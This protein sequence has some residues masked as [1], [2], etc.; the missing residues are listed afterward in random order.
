MATSVVS[1]SQAASTNLTDA[2]GVTINAP[3]SIASGDFLVAVLSG[4]YTGSVVWSA[5]PGWTLAASDHAASVSLE[6]RI[7]TKTVTGS[8]PSSYGWT[9]TGGAGSYA[10]VITAYRGTI[11][12]GTV[13]SGSNPNSHVNTTSQTPSEPLVTSPTWPGLGTYA[14]S[15]HATGSTGMSCTGNI[16]T[17]RGDISTTDG[18]PS[19]HERG[20]AVYTHGTNHA[21]GSYTGTGTMT[22]SAAPTASVVWTIDLMDAPAAAWSSTAPAATSSWT[23][24]RTNRLTWAS[25][26]AAATGAFVAGRAGPLVELKINGTWTDVTDFVRYEEGITVT[27]GRSAE[28]TTMSTSTCTF[29]LDNRTDTAQNRWSLH[30]VNGIYYGL[31][32]RN[33]EIRVSKL[34]GSYRFWGEISSWTPGAD[35][36]NND[37]WVEIEAAGLSRRLEANAARVLPAIQREILAASPQPL[38]YWPMTEGQGSTQFASA[39][40]GGAPMSYKGGLPD[41]GN[42]TN[43]AAG[44]AIPQINTASIALPYVPGSDMTTGYTF[45]F[46]LASPGGITAQTTLLTINPIDGFEYNGYTYRPYWGVGY[47]TTNTLAMDIFPGSDSGGEISGTVP[48]VGTNGVMVYASVDVDASA[49]PAAGRMH[50]Y[51]QGEGDASPVLVGSSTWGLQVGDN[52]PTKVAARINPN[53]AA[54]SDNSAAYI[55]HVSQWAGYAI[56]YSFESI[57]AYSGEAAGDRFLRL[58]SEKGIPAVCDNSS[59]ST[60][61]GP[62]RPKTFME[63]VRECE[64][65]DL[66]IL[67]ETRDQLGFRYIVRSDLYNKAA[68][69]VLD[70]SN[71]ELS[72]QLQPV[73]DDKGVQN[74]VT[75]QRDGGSSAEYVVESGPLSVNDPPNGVGRYTSSETVSLADDFDCYAQAGWRAH[76]GTV[77]EERIA[78]VGVALENP[79]VDSNHNLKLNILDADS[80]SRL[81]ILNTPDWIQ[82]VDQIVQGLSERFDNF[83][84]QITYNT[85]SAAPYTIAVAPTTTTSTTAKADSL[86]STLDSDIDSTTT[87]V[88]VDVTGVLWRTGTVSFDIAIGGEQ[89]TVTSVSGT[90]SP[91]TFTVTRS[92]N[93]IVKS[94][95]AGDQ[96]SLAQ[97]AIIAL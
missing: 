29:K 96:V 32:G 91:Q 57:G 82:E 35:D 50:L 83:G 23:A 24:A 86:T 44:D 11:G 78:S 42:Y 60:P 74:D 5:P 39:L 73:F 12:L 89:M 64:A 8:E 10:G 88:S 27:R 15:W 2:N 84:H 18:S 87:S 71:G 52:A 51:Y 94:H 45:A 48:I 93:G 70:Y 59:N 61:M 75:V 40:D 46:F 80:G 47:K 14:V 54:L 79:Q 81:M 7:Y 58:C 17:E 49:S 90:S 65:S 34:E 19:T 85:S 37:Q 16:G 53:N 36:T 3:A 69:L 56:P 76:L 68:D 41:F 77:D 63:L 55:G 62:Q 97:P 1:S 22:M 9:T 33:T 92:V 13:G 4:P 72:S 21:A 66:G 67:T 26:A 38:G 43:W 6:S 20:V 95:T 25:S 30:N 28:G 31:I